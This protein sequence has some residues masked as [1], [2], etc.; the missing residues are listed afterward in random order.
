M[1]PSAQVRASAAQQPDRLPP[2]IAQSRA[3]ECLPGLLGYGARML[4]Y[5]L[6]DERLVLRV[7]RRTEEQLIN[8]SGSTGKTVL[9]AG[10]QLSTITERELR[11]LERAHSYI[12]AFLPDTTPFPDLDLQGEFRYY[13]LQ[14]RV[15]I[16]QDL[17][18]CVDSMPSQES[19]LSLERFVRDVRDMVSSLQL[20]PDLAGKGNLVL[21]EHGMVRLIDINN[22]RRMVTDEELESAIPEG[23]DLDDYALGRKDIRRLLPRDF[24]DDL[25][26][27][28]GDLS[29]AALQT[30]EIRGLGRD[31]DAV[32]N[33]PFYK[34]L[35]CERRRLALALLRSDLA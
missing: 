2:Q 3:S 12:G 13:S 30:L 20:I 27:P 11:D 35:Q 19:R 1:E 23:I 34:P 28:I 16:Q 10:H 33:D 18:V 31:A 32:E 17:R 8:R 15:R 14:K 21:D 6:V 9:A 4:I 29:F 25:G 24:L 5:P 7:P 26:N 22:F